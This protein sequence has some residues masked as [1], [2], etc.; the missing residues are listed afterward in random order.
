[1]EDMYRYTMMSAMNIFISPVV[2]V[3]VALP[4]VIYILAR[5]RTY[6]DYGG[7][8]PHL[9]AKVAL[10][11]FRIASFQLLLAGGFLFLYGLL[12]TMNGEART[13]IFRVAGGLFLPG[14]LVFAAHTIALNATNWR[15]MPAAVRM[16]NGV[17]LVQTGMVGFASLVLAFV[18]LLQKDVP[19]EMNRMA[20]SLALVYVPAWIGQ[21]A[22]FL[23]MTVEEELPRAVVRQSEEVTRSGTGA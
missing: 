9:G 4:V 22:M 3:A 17:N 21:G 15:S 11:V 13:S 8:D 7:G 19:S 2:T 12:T 5:W 16:F 23:R 14:L 1:M 20:W 10:S 6:R 18:L